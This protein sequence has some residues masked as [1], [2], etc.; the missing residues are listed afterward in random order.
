MLDMDA[1]FFRTARRPSLR[2][3]VLLG[4][5]SIFLAN[6]CRAQDAPRVAGQDVPPP[7]RTRTI[8][9]EFPAEAQA[10][11]L[12]GIVILELII[13]TEGHVADATLIRS[14]PPFDDAALAAV[15]KWEYE[16]TRV[17]GKPVRVSLTVPITFALRLPE[18]SRQ[19]GIP[20]LRQG[21]TPAFPKAKGA[22]KVTADITLDSEGRIADALITEGEGVWADSLLQALRTWRF[23]PPDEAAVFSFRLEAE[24]LA[25]RGDK[26]QRVAL[27][28]SGLRKAAL[29]EAPGSQGGSPAGPAPAPTGPINA[30]P[31]EAPAP[32][33]TPEPGPGSAP[34]PAAA[35]VT[36]PEAQEPARAAQP[37][38][39]V[40]T[41]PLPAPPVAAVP[42]PTQPG[43]SAVD[44]VALA[45]GVP[46]LVTGRRPSAPPF[47]RLA[48]EFGSVE[49]KFAVNAAGG[50]SVLSVDG[51]ALL[52]PAAEVTVASWSFR[53]TRPERLY[54]TAALSYRAE[55]AQAVVT[56]TPP[57]L[58]PAPR[59]VPNP[60]PVAAPAAGAIPAAT[61]ESPA[62][63]P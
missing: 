59:P 18:V 26:P 48:G 44:G 40:L 54:L 4:A 20:E 27:R 55:G 3:L 58:Q 28:L 45:L 56:P 35:P 33:P 23:A 15:R 43:V 30:G 46:D 41:A 8:L 63:K 61:P 7:K 53:R 47:A 25:A 29:V 57:D 31:V 32:I 34:P 38:T 49:V 19:E 1:F 6:P 13:D 24:Y 16:I 21:A 52:K 39:D 17:D 10:R 50:A 9:P 60:L 36:P 42:P 12:H 11:G 51:P 37:P 2:S 5:V 14:V 62:P 22:A